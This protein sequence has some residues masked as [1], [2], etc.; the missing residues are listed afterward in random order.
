MLEVINLILINIKLINLI[1]INLK[2]MSLK[3]KFK[4]LS[5]S[6]NS[7]T[8]G[9]LT[10]VYKHST[11]VFTLCLYICVCVNMYVSV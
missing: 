7:S 1:L 3:E 6:V 11:T 9:L 5:L 8:V 10:S 2:L 4:L